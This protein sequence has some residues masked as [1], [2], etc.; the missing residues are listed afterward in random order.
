MPSAVHASQP[1]RFGVM[2]PAQGIKEFALACI[3]QIQDLAKLELLIVDISPPRSTSWRKKAK[4]IACLKGN[5]WLL[6]NRL[7]PIS[8]IPAYRT[9][10]IR[11]CFPNIPALPCAVTRKGKWSEYFS[12]EDIARIREY[13][14][15]FIL[16]FGYGIIR[17]DILSAARYGIW[18][19]H[20]DDE[21]KYRGGP[22]AF[23]E[24]YQNDPVTGAV[25]QRLTETLD[26]GVVLKKIWV[27]T[28]GNSHA[29]NLQRIQESSA[30]M[31]RWVCLD[32]LN[33]R[34]DYLEKAAEKPRAPIYRAPNDLQMLKFWWRILSNRIRY[35]LSDQRIDIWNI[36]LVH[37]S[38]EAFLD[39]SFQP[40][41]KWL[42]YRER[43]QMVADPNL[44]PSRDGLRILC[45]EF[46]WF[47]EAGRI[48]EIR[49]ASDG[50]F[51]CGTVAID[52]GVHMSYP[53][54]FQYGDNLYCIPECNK[55]K[56]VP[57]YR[58]DEKTQRWL[59][60][61]AL[62]RGIEAVDAT[63]FEAY[64]AWWLF[65]S[66]SSGVGR[67]SLYIWKAS[68]P[69]GPW[70]PHPANPVKTDVSSSRPAG[71]P[72]WY[73]GQLYRPAQ[74]LR[75]CYGSALVINRIDVL[76]LTEFH[77]TTVR[78]VSPDPNWP[79][80]HGIHTLNSNGELTVI[81][82]KRHAWPA[83]LILKR[84][85]YKT[86]GRPRPSIFRYQAS[87]F[88]CDPGPKLVESQASSQSE[89]V[90]FSGLRQ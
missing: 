26:G 50:S 66:M 79:Y 46:N 30:H 52:E 48:L 63:V 18:S 3:E 29:A 78:R 62:L 5:L 59:Y 7:F 31:V 44:A 16:K 68:D 73:K 42:P 75:K 14:L 35:K 9:R 88:R 57:L 38:P 49:S 90:P 83:T 86:L 82:A 24:I 69:R 20:H 80:P 47:S 43:Y 8:K 70:Q 60:E 65:H 51:A 22:P 58:W 21:Q 54:T 84:C 55:R 45:E 71:K 28:L 64:G 40:E 34:A 25:L 11:E 41:I 76:S 2:C 56:E 32:V 53:F 4:K 10:P 89:H 13:Q 27:P 37:A 72:F 17:G 61:G 1:L 36:G 81:D 33:G 23:W 85:L 87:G 19:F 74:D 12:T 39:E 77:E 6:Q 67:W 15:D